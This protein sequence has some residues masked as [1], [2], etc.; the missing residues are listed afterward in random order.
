MLSSRGSTEDL[1]GCKSY[2]VEKVNPKSLHSPPPSP[3]ITTFATDKLSKTQ[4]AHR[5]VHMVV[6]TEAAGLHVL[7][8]AE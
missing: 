1:K 3:K 4:S 2:A 6:S 8:R 5:P 7:T